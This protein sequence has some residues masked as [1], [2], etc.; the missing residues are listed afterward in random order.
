M[1][2]SSGYSRLAWQ[3]YS[4]SRRLF[5]DKGNL[6]PIHTLSAEDAAPFV[7]FDVVVKNVAGGDGHTDTVIKVLLKD[8]RA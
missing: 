3:V 6:R 1:L 8:H 7:G 4:D 5:D 2:T